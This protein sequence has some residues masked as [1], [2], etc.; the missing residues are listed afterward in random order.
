MTHLQQ[1]EVWLTA[2]KVLEERKSV[3]MPWHTFMPFNNVV[4]NEW[5][6]SVGV[7]LVDVK[8]GLLLC[9]FAQ[10]SSVYS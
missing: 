7:S 2:G 8:D 4:V 1:S 3:E 6:G 5:V 10:H 9:V